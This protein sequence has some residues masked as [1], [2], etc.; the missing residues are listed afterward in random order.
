M[1]NMIVTRFN[2][3][4]R[5]VAIF[6][7]LSSLIIAAT[8]ATIS[9]MQKDML[10]S[11]LVTQL[12]SSTKSQT[13]AS[14]LCLTR[15]NRQKLDPHFLA[16]KAIDLGT[17]RK[18]EGLGLQNMRKRAEEIDGKLTIQTQSGRGTS[19]VVI[20]PVFDKYGARAST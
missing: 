3:F 17:L 19:I 8:L 15:V 4:A 2:H 13:L 5:D 11:E 7:V 20:L 12:S 6:I 10:A 14:P 18:S 16:P 1:G 9:Q